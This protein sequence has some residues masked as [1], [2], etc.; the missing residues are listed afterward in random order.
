MTVKWSPCAV[1]FAVVN[2]AFA[3]V[4]ILDRHF[5]DILVIPLTQISAPIIIV[6]PAVPLT[7]L[8]TAEEAAAAAAGWT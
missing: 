3:D 6:N 5:A 7:S 4:L 1:I 2:P 8:S